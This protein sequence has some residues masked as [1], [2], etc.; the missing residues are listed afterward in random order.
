M[1]IISLV[2]Q[3][4]GVAK[5]TSVVNIAGALTKLNKK[6]LVVDIDPQGNC[7]TNFGFETLETNTI[8]E[9]LTDNNIHIEDCILETK[10][11]HL[12]P[13][14]IGLAEAEFTLVNKMAREFI[15]RK[16]LE[17]VKNNY[18]YCLIDC[19]PSLSTLT[20]NA[21]VASH[22]VY[23]PMM[24]SKFSVKGIQQLLDTINAVQT[25]NEDLKLGGVFITN[26]DQRNNLSTSYLEQVQN[27]LTDKILLPTKIRINIDLAKAQDY[28]ENIFEFNEKSNGA[29][30]YMDLTN[31]ILEREEK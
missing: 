24:T 27:V 19:P 9:L 30:D 15:L 18:D 25:Y 6:V 2:N 20:L 14:D 31:D 23:V 4:G 26:Y 3:K 21:L 12:I 10:G 11:L 22:K 7:T 29:K 1:K 5:T 16:K 28:N 17:K 13:A 8:A